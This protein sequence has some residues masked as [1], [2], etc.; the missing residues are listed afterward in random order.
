MHR[1]VYL[2]WQTY[3]KPKPKLYV[4][5]CLVQGRVVQEQDNE[6]WAGDY[7]N[8]VHRIALQGRIHK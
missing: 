4:D 8:V 2:S 5:F 1:T 6:S 7:V 3:S